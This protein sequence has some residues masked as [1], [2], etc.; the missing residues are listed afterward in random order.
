MCGIVVCGTECV[1]CVYQPWLE[2]TYQLHLGGL[3]QLR[4]IFELLQCSIGWWNLN[5]Q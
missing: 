5:V 4:A 1:Y 3:I 2:H